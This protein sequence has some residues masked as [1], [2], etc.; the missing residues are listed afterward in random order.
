MAED[1][2]RRGNERYSLSLL[3]NVWIHDPISDKLLDNLATLVGWYVIRR[4]CIVVFKS[5][6]ETLIHFLDTL[7]QSFNVPSL[8]STHTLL[9]SC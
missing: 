9:S 7:R 6:Y 4:S 2:Q 1:S 8:N 3:H 5:L